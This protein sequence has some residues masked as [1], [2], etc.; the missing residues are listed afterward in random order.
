MVPFLLPS[1]L[2]P[3]RLA[4]SLDP[5]RG[6]VTL[7]LP[8]YFSGRTGDIS[9]HRSALIF[10]RVKKLQEAVVETLRHLKGEAR[11]RKA[12]GFFLG[13]AERLLL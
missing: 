2:S 3:Q 1:N 8:G 13:S 6:E 9:H 12:P 4:T 10:D 5:F 11:L 7:S